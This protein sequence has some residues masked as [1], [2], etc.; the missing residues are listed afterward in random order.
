[1]SEVAD[2]VDRGTHGR[3][4]GTWRSPAGERVRSFTDRHNAT[5]NELCA[6]LQNR[7]PEPK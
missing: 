5:P 6:E 2:A 4:M 3:V 7:M 1:M